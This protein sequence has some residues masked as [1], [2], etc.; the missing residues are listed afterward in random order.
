MTFIRSGLILTLVF[1][2][3]APAMA[4]EPV[5]KAV[6]NALTDIVRFEQQAQGLTPAR[7]SNARRILKL[8]DLSYERLQGA[9]RTDPAWQEVNQR[10]VTLKAGLEQLL[11]PGASAAS[12]PVAPPSAAAAAVTPSAAPAAATPPELVSGQR[13]QVQKLTRDIT[14]VREGLVTSGPSPFQDAQEVTARQKRMKQ[15]EE[16][17]ARYPQVNDPDVQAARA[18]YEQLRQALSAEFQRSREQLG[19]LGDVE[20][21]LATMETNGRTY[22]VPAPLTVP[23]SQQDAAAWVDA[24]G[25]ARTVAEH[26][27]KELAAIA[28]LAYLPNN[29]GTPQTGAA[30]DAQD[31]DRLQ[32][33][34]RAALQQ[35]QQGYEQMAADLK[36]RLAQI[37]NDVLTRF[38]EDPAGEKSWVYLRKSAAGE[39]AQVYAD[40]LAQAR[41]SLYLEKALGRDASAA[42]AVIAKI[43]QAQKDFAANRTAALKASRLP[44]AKSQDKKLLAIARE[45]VRNPKYQF[46]EHGP[47]VLTTAQVVDRERKD[48][49][50]EIDDAEITL[51]GDLKMSGTET[52]WTY[53]WQEFKFAVPLKEA[54]S[55]DWHI[56]W[57]TAKNFSSGGPKTPL[58]DWISGGTTQGNLILKNNF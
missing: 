25:K 15:F 27:L 33:N 16:A 49:E 58:N 35:L 51:S 45:I 7:A 38:R 10:Y 28:P 13:V 23:F 55:D 12:A 37:E 57:I 24:A 52:T 41:S 48:S 44:T 47:I 21:R 4:A 46:G 8:L 50:I 34:S 9:D 36:T 11:Q 29:P 54:D 3:S 43:E 1:A 18:A 14:A 17:L 56:W 42:E 20:Q 53:K 19:Q 2:L 40:A 22:P 30:Y 26:N 39:A 32:R 5:D 31:V 6:Q